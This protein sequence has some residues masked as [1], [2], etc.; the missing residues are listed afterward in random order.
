[1]FQKIFEDTKW[2]NRSRK[3]KKDGQKYHGQTEKIQK[4]K[5]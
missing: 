2:V 4:D 5:Q 3:L 1:M